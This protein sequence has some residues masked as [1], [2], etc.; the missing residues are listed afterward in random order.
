MWPLC[1][2][3]AGACLGCDKGAPCPSWGTA[4][5]STVRLAVPL[6]GGRHVPHGRCQMLHAPECPCLVPSGPLHG[7][8]PD[9]PLGR[10][11]LLGCR[12]GTRLGTAVL[13]G[14]TWSLCTGHLPTPPAERRVQHLRGHCTALPS[15]P[16]LL[17]RACALPHAVRPSLLAEGSQQE[18]WARRRAGLPCGSAA[19]LGAAHPTARCHL[20]CLLLSLCQCKGGISVQK[21]IL[22]HLIHPL[23]WRERGGDL[24]PLQLRVAC[25]EPR[26]VV[27]SLRTRCHCAGWGLTLPPLRKLSQLF[28]LSCF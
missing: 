9:Q 19:L 5:I 13:A 12:A 18:P 14:A 20:P 6:G 16:P 4:S 21:Q 10:G 28:Y 27:R 7:G 26:G 3:Q 25:Q 23:H 17:P 8:G 11:L 24:V 1:S 15:A 2:Q 22:Q